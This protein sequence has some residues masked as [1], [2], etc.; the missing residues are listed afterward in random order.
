MVMSYPYVILDIS[1]QR[2]KTRGHRQQPLELAFLRLDHC[3]GALLQ[4]DEARLPGEEEERPDDSEPLKWVR[5]SLG[6]DGEV[7]DEER[8]IMKTK[9]DPLTGSEV[10]HSHGSLIIAF[11]ASSRE[12]SCKRYSRNG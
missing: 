1:L 6:L 11:T 7:D 5:K 10:R 8:D 9:E 12:S 2:H 4:W 3:G